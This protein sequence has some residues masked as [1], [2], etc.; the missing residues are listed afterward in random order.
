MDLARPAH[1]RRRRP[2]RALQRVGRP[3]RSPAPQ[4]GSRRDARPARRGA[5][6]PPAPQLDVRVP[7]CGGLL[8]P[9]PEVSRPAASLLAI[10]LTVG[11]APLSAQDPAPDSLRSFTF[12]GNVVDYVTEVPIEGASVGLVEVRRLAIT[13]AHGYF[14][15]ADLV[16]GRYTISTTG[17][18]YE[19][20]RESSDVPFGAVLVV[21]LSPAPLDVAGLEV[22][23]ARFVRQ[24]EMRRLATPVPSSGFDRE[25]LDR[26]VDYDLVEFIRERTTLDIVE[27]SFGLPVARFRNRV[28]RLR[29]CLDE[30]PVGA[31]FLQNL[32][33]HQ[34]GRVEVFESA[35]MVRLYTN[36]FLEEAAERGFQLRPVDLTSARGC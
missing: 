11:T 17:F 6:L 25:T 31:G 20:N 5:R 1:P 2:Q 19:P 9:V 12:R 29:V 24:I 21:R 30:F 28:S 7:R 22:E 13:D 33:P 3:G 16:P 4:G 8:R 34:L 27:D 35:R 15:F 36:E 23:I 18:G 14:E 10:V 32:Q 26:T